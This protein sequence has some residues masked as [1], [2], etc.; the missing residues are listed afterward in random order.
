MSTLLNSLRTPSYSDPRIWS[1][2]LYPTADVAVLAIDGAHAE[3]HGDTPDTASR[4]SWATPHLM[5]VRVRTAKSAQSVIRPVRH[6]RAARTASSA[7]TRGVP[8][9]PRERACSPPAT[10]TSAPPRSTPSTPRRR[11]PR[12]DPNPTHVRDP[13]RTIRIQASMHGP[14]SSKPVPHVPMW[15]ARPHVLLRAHFVW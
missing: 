12:C 11:G 3:R 4:V 1:T 9:L 7:W 5:C 14:L 15:C 6:G 13:I 8:G 10:H 2:T